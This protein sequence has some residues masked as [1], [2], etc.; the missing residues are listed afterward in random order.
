[1]GWNLMYM[2]AANIASDPGTE[3][4]R[5]TAVPEEFAQRNVG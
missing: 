5:W 1:M 4:A 3:L 2:Q